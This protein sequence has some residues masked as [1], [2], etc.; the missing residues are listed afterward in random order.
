MGVLNR[1]ICL[2][3]KHFDIKVDFME[4][5]HLYNL[6]KREVVWDD[7][8]LELGKE[9]FLFFVRSGFKLSPRSLESP[10]ECSSNRST[11]LFSKSLFHR[12][13]K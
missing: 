4:S 10:D 13:G 8:D 11:A 12:K 9:Y 5:T 2:S 1:F 6:E 7:V 3:L